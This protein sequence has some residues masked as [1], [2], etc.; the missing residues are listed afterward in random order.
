MEEE[1]IPHLDIIS[2]G[3]KGVGCFMVALEINKLFRGCN[4]EPVHSKCSSCRC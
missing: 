1:R 3:S 2:G 4:E